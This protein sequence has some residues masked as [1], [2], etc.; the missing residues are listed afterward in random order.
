MVGQF[1]GDRDTGA[2]DRVVLVV[3]FIV[4]CIMQLHLVW[5]IPR[6]R[7]LAAAAEVEETELTQGSDLAVEARRRGTQGGIRR[8]KPECPGTTVVGLNGLVN[9]FFLVTLTD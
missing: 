7:R 3:Y 8:C 4:W 9:G 6:A 2:I 1:H 5:A